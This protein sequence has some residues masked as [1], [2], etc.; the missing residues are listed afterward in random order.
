MAITVNDFLADDG[1]SRQLLFDVPESL[2]ISPGRSWI[3]GPGRV[4]PTSPVFSVALRDISE[5]DR[6]A[7]L[8]CLL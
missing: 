1:D 5:D 3:P 7:Q 6:S 2:A 4:E 8:Q